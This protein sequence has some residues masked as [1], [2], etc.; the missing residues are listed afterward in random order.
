MSPPVAATQGVQNT[1]PQELVELSDL[2]LGCY[3]LYKNGRTIGV[4]FHSHYFYN[5]ESLLHRYV[6][7]GWVAGDCEKNYFFLNALYFSLVSRWRD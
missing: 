2:P 3:W 4:T 6:D 5:F 7:E 1:F